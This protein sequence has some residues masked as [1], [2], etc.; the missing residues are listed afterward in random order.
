M[1][2]LSARDFAAFTAACDNAGRPDE[3]LKLLMKSSC[4]LWEATA[5]EPL[6]NEF[7]ELLAK[8]K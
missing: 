5:A 2:E 4:D 3:K 6:P 8:L 7:I 1:I